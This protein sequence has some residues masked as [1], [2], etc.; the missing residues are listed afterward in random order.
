MASSVAEAAEVELSSEQQELLQ[1]RKAIMQAEEQ[2]SGFV[3]SEVETTGPQDWHAAKV[4][5][6]RDVAA[7][8]R[9][10]TIETEVSREVRQPAFSSKKFIYG[11]V[12]STSHFRVP[13]QG[14]HRRSCMFTV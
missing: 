14:C 8:V 5:A 12:C 11:R 6:V 3:V 7:G 10:V 2:S 9:C 13:L 4:V 1:K